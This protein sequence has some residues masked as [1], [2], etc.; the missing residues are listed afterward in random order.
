MSHDPIV[1]Q[2]EIADMLSVAPGTVHQWMK[3]GLLP[4][5]EGTV[6]GDAAWH[7]STIER[8]ARETGRMPG[9]RE[10]ILD[11]LMVVGGASTTPL[12]TA[13]MGRG[14]A[15]TIGQ[16]WRVLNDL[17]NEGLIGYRAPNDWFLSDAGR[18]AVESRRDGRGPLWSDNTKLVD[19]HPA[20]IAGG[21][22]PRHR[23]YDVPN[24]ILGGNH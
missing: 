1:G 14:L 18:H 3:R 19:P 10:H 8:W 9:L 4:A 6:G 24:T 22:R 21:W 2:K 23:F 13:L 12:A 17:F 15:R 7:W 16:V 11:L 5:Q 20:D